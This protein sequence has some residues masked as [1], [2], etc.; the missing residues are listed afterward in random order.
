MRFVVKIAAVGLVLGFAAGAQGA[1]VA[2][3]SF[4]T[5]NNGNLGGQGSGTGWAGAWV[6]GSASA[7]DVVVPTSPSLTYAVPGGGVVSG[8]AKALQHTGNAT[9]AVNRTLSSAFGDDAGE[10]AIYI[11]FLMKFTGSITGNDFA[12]IWFDN[13]ASGD[14]T[15][16]PNIGL[17]ANQGSGSTGMDFFSRL[18]LGDESYSGNLVS[19]ETYLIVGRLAKSDPGNFDTF[20]LWV[21]PESND[22]DTPDVTATNVGTIAEFNMI[23]IRSANLGASDGVT[24][25]ELVL[26]TRWSDVVPTAS[27]SVPEPATLGLLGLGLLGLVWGRRRHT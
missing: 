21:N 20:D 3:E 2:N 9:N 11:S 5:L 1:V 26:G 7:S 10:T 14:H 16:R 25:D 8:G 22:F 4:N 13:N 23:G 12:A 18:A 24:I 6:D 19:G 17:K 27:T 15:N